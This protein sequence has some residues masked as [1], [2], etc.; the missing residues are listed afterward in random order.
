MRRATQAL[1]LVTGILAA[2]CSQPS[3]F[4]LQ[5]Y[6]ANSYLGHPW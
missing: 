6:N 2:D 1:L 5:V 4:S 3:L